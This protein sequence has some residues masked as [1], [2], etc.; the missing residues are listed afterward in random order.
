M[1]AGWPSG[2]AFEHDADQLVSATREAVRRRRN[3]QSAWLDLI[4]AADD[5]ADELEETAFLMQLLSAVQEVVQALSLARMAV[6]QGGVALRSQTASLFSFAAFC[7]SEQ[8][9]DQQPVDH[10]QRVLG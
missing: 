6:T 3:D 7:E 8:G 5:A 10:R 2:R 9:M 1:L 4:E